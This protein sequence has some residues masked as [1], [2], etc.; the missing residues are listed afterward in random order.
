M[1]SFVYRNTVK[2]KTGANYLK[3]KLKGKSPNLDA[4]GAKVAIY[5]GDRTQVSQQYFARGFQSSIEPGLF[6]GLGSANQLDSLVVTWPDRTRS[7]LY[8]V[9]SNQT[10]S[11]EQ[12][13]GLPVQTPMVAESSSTN[14]S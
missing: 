9:T 7:V 11:I 2:E 14:P 6:F 8:D 1:T 5:L 12:A 10:L 3:V 13:D 4:L